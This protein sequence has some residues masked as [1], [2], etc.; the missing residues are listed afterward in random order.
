MLGF[1]GKFD[2]ARGQVLQ[3]G[4]MAFVS[5]FRMMQNIGLFGI[6]NFPRN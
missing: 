1:S 5:T 2:P 6:K 3:L 4:D